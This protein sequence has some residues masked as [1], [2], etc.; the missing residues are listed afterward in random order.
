VSKA[1]CLACRAHMTVEQ[2]CSEDRNAEVCGKCCMERTAR[3]RACKEGK[4]VADYCTESGDHLGIPGC[5]ENAEDIEQHPQ[6]FLDPHLEFL[7]IKAE[8]N[9]L[10]IGEGALPFAPVSGCPEFV[11]SLYFSSKNLAETFRENLFDT[12]EERA[13]AQLAEKKFRDTF[14]ILSDPSSASVLGVDAQV[15]AV[16]LPEGPGTGR[17]S[18]VHLLYNVDDAPGGGASA[19]LRL[20]GCQPIRAAGRKG[21]MR[22]QWVLETLMMTLQLHTEKS[23]YTAWLACLTADQRIAIVESPK[24]EH[25]INMSMPYPMWTGKSTQAI[26]CPEEQEEACFEVWSNPNPNE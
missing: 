20:G 19:R 10:D 15:L 12:P 1:A 13:R 8:A 2:F 21:H 22:L 5:E 3:C 16:S 25:W 7:A 11:P 17:V 4:S 9:L 14:V 23:G 18:R 6:H 26:W 24:R